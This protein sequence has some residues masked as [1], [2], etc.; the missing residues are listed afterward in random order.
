MREKVENIFFIL[1]YYSYIY[2]IIK[3]LTIMKKKCLLFQIRGEGRLILISAVSDD[4]KLPEHVSEGQFHFGYILNY[5][6][7]DTSKY[8]IVSDL[9]ISEEIFTLVE[10]TFREFKNQ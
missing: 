5:E 3:T 4:H 6:T 1:V 10:G 2:T 8:R 7:Y 9:Y